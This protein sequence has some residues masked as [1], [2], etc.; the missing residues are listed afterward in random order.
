MRRVILALAC[1]SVGF[2]VGSLSPIGRAFAA[3]VSPA[4]VNGCLY[5][6]SAPTLATGQTYVFQCDVNG[7]LITH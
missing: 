2:G 6:S 3:L 5:Q 1:L 7:K 4:A